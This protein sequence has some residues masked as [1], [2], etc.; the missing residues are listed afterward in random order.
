MDVW[1]NLFVGALDIS[2]GDEIIVPTWTMSACATSILVWNAIPVFADISYETYNL[3]PFDVEKKITKK[4]KAIMAVRH[5]WSFCSNKRIKN[6]RKK[7]QT[8]NNL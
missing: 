6:Y 3:D 7:I 1:F 8:K 5:I 4:T 2:P